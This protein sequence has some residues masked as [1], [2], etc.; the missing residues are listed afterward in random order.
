MRELSLHNSV[1]EEKAL[2]P[3]VG[4]VPANSSNDGGTRTETAFLT[5]PP[6]PAARG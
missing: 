5:T 6:F 1:L 4:Q 3:A 2:P